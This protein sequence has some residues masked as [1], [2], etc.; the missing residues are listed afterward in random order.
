MRTTIPIGKPGFQTRWQVLTGAPHRLMFF[1]GV[2]QT[3][4]T[5]GWWLLT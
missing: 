5:I 1:F 4:L 2:L 3:V